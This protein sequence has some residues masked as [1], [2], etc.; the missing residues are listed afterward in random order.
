[1]GNCSEQVVTRMRVCHFYCH[2]AGQQRAAATEYNTCVI[3]RTRGRSNVAL[4]V[5]N[6]TVLQQAHRPV[7][8]D[9]SVQ[10][11]ATRPPRMR[12]CAQWAI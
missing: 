9:Q 7:R 1:M 2:L 8:T 5:L 3:R 12:A 11:E 6:H 4:I 10:N